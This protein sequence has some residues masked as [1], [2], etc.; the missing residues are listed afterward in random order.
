MGHEHK[1]TLVYKYTY[2]CNQQAVFEN[3]KMYNTIALK[4]NKLDTQEG[5]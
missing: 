5:I 3:W 4:N 1:F 2:T